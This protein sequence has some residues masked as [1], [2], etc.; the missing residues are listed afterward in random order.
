[1]KIAPTQAA[2]RDTRKSKRDFTAKTFCFLHQVNEDNALPASDL[3]VAL[4]LTRHF[5]QGDGGRAYPSCKLIAD[6]IGLSEAT[7]IRAVRRL[8]E[9]SHLRVEWGKAGRGH[10]NQYWMVIKPAQVQVL[11]PEKP[12]SEAARK[13]ASVKIK[14]APV[15]E[16][17]LKNH[18]GV[19]KAT[20][21]DGERGALTRSIPDPGGGPLDAAPPEEGKQESKRPPREASNV[22]HLP[23]MHEAKYRELRAVY[24]RQ[25]AE[26]E[27]DVRRAFAIA[28][29]DTDPDTIIE[30]ARLH[31]AASDGPRWLQPL[32]KWLE[33]KKW[34]VEPQKRKQRQQKVTPEFVDDYADGRIAIISPYGGQPS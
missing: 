20:P 22:V 23:V 28:C 21:L 32:T 2:R 6:T 10:P 31:V 1:M 3:K 5:N 30:G 4:Q 9:R 19:A 29:R 8:A 13:L 33:A 12:T 18:Q 26:T 7:V 27:A 25:W 17:L 34:E 14:P 16:N 15:Q 24:V 11:E